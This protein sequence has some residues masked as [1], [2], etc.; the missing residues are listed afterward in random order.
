MACR[1]E[2]AVGRRVC[3]ISVGCRENRID[4]EVIHAY[5]GENDWVV[6]DTPEEADLVVLNSC[7][8]SAGAEEAS[9]DLFRRLRGRMRPDARLIFAGCLP[10]INKQALREAGYED[11]LVTPRTLERFDEI[12]TARVPISSLDVGCL[13]E[14]PVVTG[15]FGRA[16][17]A[18]RSLVGVAERLGPLPMP[19]WL[20]QVQNLPTEETEYVRISVGCLEQCA[21]CSIRKAKG[22][23]RSVA[24]ET[25]LSRARASLQRGR[26][27][28]ALSCDEL[29]S[30]GQEFGS[31]IADLLQR[32]VALEGEFTLTLRN[33]HPRWLVRYW[34]ELEPVFTSGRV[35]YT[36]L[37]LQSGSDRVLTAMCRGYT[38]AEYRELLHALRRAAPGMIVRS[39]LLVGFPGES[40][41]DHRESCD[42]VRTIPLDHCSVFGYADRPA[43][44]ALHLEP[45]VPQEVIDRRVREMRRLLWRQ[46][47]R[48]WRWHPFR[49]PKGATR[50]VPSASLPA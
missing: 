6:V 44:A 4:G 27:N 37:P 32:L 46:Y 9:L 21:Y 20:W 15:L 36:I 23:T 10:A 45:K 16:F 48:S 12:I 8:F 7:G 43:T 38:T 3:C 11:L 24:A 26:R 50:K 31:S 42:F 13:P 25:V 1:E 5:F 14:D 2:I 40:E 34:E 49:R 39:H 35:I 29:G 19:R 30:W 28:L 41:A 33:A 22:K 18:T 17:R 47:G